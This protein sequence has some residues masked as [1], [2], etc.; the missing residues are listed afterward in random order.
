MKISY[1]EYL[2]QLEGSTL[3]REKFDSMLDRQWVE[4]E[5]ETISIEE[6]IKELAGSPLNR[7]QF[8]TILKRN[9]IRVEKW[10]YDDYQYAVLNWFKG[11]KWE[12]T[13]KES[14]GF[15]S[16]AMNN[17]DK[18]AMKLDQK[19]DSFDDKV[20]AIERVKQDLLKMPQEVLKVVKWEVDNIK[21]SQKE[22]NNKTIQ[23][24]GK[25]A[26]KDHKH[27]I[28]DV[29]WLNDK[30]KSLEWDIEDRPTRD[31]IA[32]ALDEQFVTKDNTYTKEETRE[33]LK[34]KLDNIIIPWNRWGGG[35][36]SWLQSV[37]AWTNITV[38]NT[39]PLNPII[40]ATGW[41][42]G[43]AV[44]SVFGRTWVVTAQSW[45]YTADQV[46]ETATKVFVTPSE[47]TAITHSN[48]AV[49][50][51]TTAS[52][53][54]A[55]ETKLDWIEAW[56]EVN[57]I[58]DV[59]ATD[60][61]D[62]GTTSLHNHDD[63]YTPTVDLWDLAT[64]DTVNTDQIDNSAVTNA[65]LA[66]MNANTVKGR[67]SGNGVPQDIAMADLP[68]SDATQTAL[69]AKA[70]L[71][72]TETLTNKTIALWS[73]TVSWT[74]AQFD[75]ACTDD[76]FAFLGQAN[77]FTGNQTINGIIYSSPWVAERWVEWHNWELYNRTSVI[78]LQS[79]SWLPVSINPL[80]NDLLVNWQNRTSG[81][82]SYTPTINVWSWSVTY[83]QQFW[84]YKQIGKVIFF[85]I[86]IYASKNTASWGITVNLPVSSANSNYDV[87]LAWQINDI[88]ANIAS[89]IWKPIL[90]WSWWVL[91]FQK[92][93]RDANVSISDLWTNFCIQLSWTYEAS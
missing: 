85:E 1:Q 5:R 35:S 55:D 18:L 9:K 12:Y 78:R 46:T 52:F 42:G 91:Y 10:E 29:D 26:D 44:D 81:W 84:K 4:V 71:T 73:N 2:K 43:W 17:S 14:L 79:Y 67:L 27:K 48:R 30:I 80:W 8:D 33:L 45:D 31:E 70:S 63:R 37:V 89:P 13:K 72:W 3:S 40:N 61:T 20:K 57:N 54:T 39:D 21:D 6:Y 74:K 66:H 36:S 82:T 60:L 15:L 83:N 92:T 49:L 22:Y 24:L 68:I 47:K 38:D 16:S 19:I 28:K 88:S 77:T 86:S 41:G 32:Q 25:K 87:M 34:K 90:N 53:T 7:D 51:A 75:T 93:T 56:A 11:T 23:N 65:K 58:S 76:N 59:N 50:D 64:L 69:N 62:W